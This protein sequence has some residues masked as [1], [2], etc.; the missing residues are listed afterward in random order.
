M[1]ERMRPRQTI[2]S[3]ARLGLGISGL[4]FA[5][6]VS[7]P[8]FAQSAAAPGSDDTK[9]PPP[10]PSLGLAPGT[11]QVGTLPGG[12]TPAYGQAPADQQDWR[13]DFHGFLTMP[14]R[15][16]VNTRSGVVTT[17]QHTLVLHAPP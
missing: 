4:V 9:A 15:A 12:L 14:L 5:V 6:S 11:P 13:F 17:D 3:R 7:V 8:A 10:Q 1:G 2:G 16:G